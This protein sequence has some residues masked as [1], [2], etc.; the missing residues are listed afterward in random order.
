M[1]MVMAMVMVG[2]GN[3]GG[4]DGDNGG[5]ADDGGGGDGDDNGNGDDD[6]DGEGD[7][8]DDT[9]LKWKLVAAVRHS[10]LLGNLTAHITRN[11]TGPFQKNDI[12]GEK[13]VWST[14]QSCL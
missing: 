12:L 13:N 4:G 11:I 3:G 7:N 1:M 6:D 14:K 2:D 8:G 9:S 10:V 5:D